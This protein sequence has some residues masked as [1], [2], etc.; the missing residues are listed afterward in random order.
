MLRLLGLMCCWKYNLA[1]H[2]GRSAGA[3]K[4]GA[5][6]LIC[7][8]QR[9]KISFQISIYPL[10]PA[11][12][13]IGRIRCPWQIKLVLSPPKGSCS[14]SEVRVQ[15][16]LGSSGNDNVYMRLDRKKNIRAYPRCMPSAQKNLLWIRHRNICRHLWTVFPA[17]GY[18]SAGVIP[19]LCTTTLDVKTGISESKFRVFLV[20]Y[21]VEHKIGALNAGPKIIRGYNA[22]TNG[23]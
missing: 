20:F 12:T 6:R 8:H 13:L 4:C 22:L 17:P 23:V 5:G 1:R 7:A 14:H 2:R 21:A 11:A 16:R 3:L 19:R 9:R 18:W 10:T 15:P